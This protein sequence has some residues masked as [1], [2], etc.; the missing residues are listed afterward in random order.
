VSAAA[1]VYL[2]HLSFRQRENEQRDKCLGYFL[3]TSAQIRTVVSLGKIVK[4][5]RKEV[6]GLKFK[7]ICD[8]SGIESPGSINVSIFIVLLLQ[9]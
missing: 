9:N 3:L 6:D 4:D 8:N 5:T 7:I 1:S 2:L